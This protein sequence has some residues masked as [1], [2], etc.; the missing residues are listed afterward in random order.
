MLLVMTLHSTTHARLE[1]DTAG[2]LLIIG[3]FIAFDFRHP[4][5][6]D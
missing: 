1:C 3:G 6:E 5:N 2:P 4:T